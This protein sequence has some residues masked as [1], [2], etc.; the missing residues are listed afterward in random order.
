MG[1][2]R[3]QGRGPPRHR[4][5]QA[6][7]GALESKE[8]K[9]TD[10]D[11]PTVDLIVGDAVA[12]CL[13]KRNSDR[14]LLAC[15]HATGSRC[16]R[17]RV[18]VAQLWPVERLELLSGFGARSAAVAWLHH[19]PSQ[20]TMAGANARASRLVSPRRV[21]SRLEIQDS[22]HCMY[23]QCTTSAAL[24]VVCEACVQVADSFCFCPGR[25][26]RL[27]GPPVKEC[28][29]HASRIKDPVWFVPLSMAE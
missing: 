2:T 26:L 28:N 11:A 16:S 12:K 20:P 18:T 15:T 10:H 19:P 1:T 29:R 8:V 23:V 17:W 6:A 13:M 27:L 5:S 4:A 21:A 3:A 25:E 7:S 9:P 24:T 22:A 14:A